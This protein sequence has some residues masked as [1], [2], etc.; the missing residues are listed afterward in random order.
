MPSVTTLPYAL[1]PVA[2]RVNSLCSVN[3]PETRARS[4]VGL[5]EQH[6]ANARPACGSGRKDSLLNRQDDIAL[7]RRLGGDS[8]YLQC[9]AKLPGLNRRRVDSAWPCLP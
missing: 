8:R 2:V 7:L 1:R 6:R 5:M 4:F 9:S 3:K